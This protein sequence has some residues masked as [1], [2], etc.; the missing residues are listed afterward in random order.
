MTARTDG[1]AWR[2]AT[3][4]DAGALRDL[5]R[6]AS[7]L[8]LA[9][10]FGDLPYPA[11]DVLARWTV[12]LDD[13]G[14]VVEV[15][16]RPDGPGLLALCA[17]DAT[18]RHLAVH[19]SAWGTGLARDAVARAVAGG[20]RRLWVLELNARARGVYEHLG[21][22]ASGATQECPWPPYPTELEY[23]AAR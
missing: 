1:S 23:V 8:G 3:T 12:V 15:I 9:H 10:V 4:T 6:D 21:W 19:P 17:Y 18:L 11:D 20:A 14:V 13:P 7:L 16:D 2:R 5:E 22:S